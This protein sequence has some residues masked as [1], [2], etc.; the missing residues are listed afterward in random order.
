[1]SL[2]IIADN[3]VAGVTFQMT[4]TDAVQGITG[5]KKFLDGVSKGKAVGA[6]VSVETKDIRFAFGVDPT[7]SLGHPCSAGGSIN[8]YGWQEVN[9]FR[10]ISASAGQAATLTIT[11]RHST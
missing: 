2:S 6:L 11:V 9:D 7:T 8:L 10:F 3:G 5:T 1:M 4:S